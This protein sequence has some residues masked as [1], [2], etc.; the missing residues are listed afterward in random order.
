[1]SRSMTFGSATCSCIAPPGSWE[2]S[3]GPEPTASSGVTSPHPGTTF[4]AMVNTSFL[5]TQFVKLLPAHTR[6]PETA[7]GREVFVQLF[8]TQVTSTEADLNINL[9]NSAMALQAMRDVGIEPVDEPIRGGTN[10]SMLTAKGVPTPN[11]FT[12]MHE[13]YGPLECVTVQDMEL[14]TRVCSQL[15]RNFANTTQ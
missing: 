13:V 7:T 3:R 2:S 15:A 10:G 12:G 5:A 1:M 11:I 8:Q 9:R 4:H 6:T 14:A